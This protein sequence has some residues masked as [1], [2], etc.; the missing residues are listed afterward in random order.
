MMHL[1]EAD[2]RDLL[3]MDDA[4]AALERMFR[5]LAVGAAQTIPRRRAKTD[6]VMLHLLGGAALG[7]VGYKAYTTSR[8]GARFQVGLFDGATG[9]PL[10]VIDADILGQIRTGAASGVATRRLARPDSRV[11]GLFG[12]GKQARTQALA[13]CRATPTIERIKVFSRDEANRAAFAAEMT[14]VC[15][16]RIEPVANPEDAVRGCDVVVTA[17]TSKTPVFDGSWLEPGTHLNVVGSNVLSKAEIDVETIR[18]ADVVTID[19]VEQGKLEAGDFVAALEAGTLDW[20]GVVPLCEVVAGR[21]PG[22]TDRSQ[23]TLF[24]S[25][26]LG[27]EDVAVAALVYRRAASMPRR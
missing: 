11:V 7:F 2:V 8:G 22:R 27:V 24:K 4:I 15:G 3:T 12:A 16:C 20:P 5:D 21:H 13:V 25:L 17:T 14:P 26:G 18:R 10:A 23:I 19:D 6:A 1:T 9:E